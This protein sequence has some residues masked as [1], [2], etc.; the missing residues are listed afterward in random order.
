MTAAG[1]GH[2]HEII[3]AQSSGGWLGYITYGQTQHYNYG[4]SLLGNLGAIIVYATLGLISL[5]FLTNFRLGEWI[6]TWL[7]KEYVK[8][9][10]EPKS[11]EESALE[12]RA[13]ELEKQA[14]KLQEEVGAVRSRRGPAARA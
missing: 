7:D 14:K 4:L 10:P 8:A 13:R 3:G 1:V 5:L 2:F 11:A 6:R 9:K 12:K